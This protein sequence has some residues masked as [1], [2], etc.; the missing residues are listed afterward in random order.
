MANKID[1]PISGT[2]RVAP[3]TT[4]KVARAGENRE[5]PVGAP[6]AAD[7]VRITGEASSLR[8]IERDLTSAPAMDLDKVEAVR[9]ALA[10]GSYKIDAQAIALR[11]VAMERDLSA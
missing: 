2:P 7:R 11:M 5:Q 9:T 10:E 4:A 8:A 3:A 6:E 1:G